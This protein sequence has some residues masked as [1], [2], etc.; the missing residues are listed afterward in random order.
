MGNKKLTSNDN[1]PFKSCISKISNPFIDNVDNLDIV[2]STYNL[3]E[4]SGKYSM[5]S[6]NL[7]NYYKNEVN[8][9]ANK[10]DYA[11]N[12]RINSNKTTTSK[13]FEYN[14]KILGSIPNNN[15]SLDTEV[16]VPLKYLRNFCR[17]RFTFD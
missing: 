9:N 8:D 15:S 1:A 17:S 16:V 5:T 13:S 3:L 14:T 6:W 4:Y 2:M 10:N 12:Y 11:D 7:W